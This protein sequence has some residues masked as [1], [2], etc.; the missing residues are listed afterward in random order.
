M[1]RH[2]RIRRSKTQR[3]REEGTKTKAVLD[4]WYWVEQHWHGDSCP[5]TFAD[6]ALALVEELYQCQKAI[7]RGALREP[8]TLEAIDVWQLRRHGNVWRAFGDLCLQHVRTGDDTKKIIMSLE[9]VHVLL[10]HDYERQAELTGVRASAIEK[11]ISLAGDARDKIYSDTAKLLRTAIEA[12]GRQIRD[13]ALSDKALVAFEVDQQD[14]VIATRSIVTKHVLERACQ[15]ALLY[16][17]LQV[18]LLHQTCVID[19]TAARTSGIKLIPFDQYIRDASSVVAVTPSVPPPV[20]SSPGPQPPVGVA[21]QTAPHGVLDEAL[22]WLS[23]EV[24]LRKEHTQQVVYVAEQ[25]LGSHLGRRLAIALAKTDAEEKVEA[26]VA[27]I[28]VL[29]RDGGTVLEILGGMSVAVSYGRKFE[30][31]AVRVLVLEKN[32]E[33]IDQLT[34]IRVRHTCDAVRSRLQLLLRKCL[35]AKRPDCPMVHG[36]FVSLVSSPMSD[37]DSSWRTLFEHLETGSEHELAAVT[38]TDVYLSVSTSSPARIR[39][40]YEYQPRTAWSAVAQAWFRRAWKDS[41]E[42]WRWFGSP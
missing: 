28:D 38:T 12:R 9:V 17:H 35:D 32:Q 41:L 29:A 40:D 7:G 34:R 20:V 30:R 11:W 4:A 15:I 3:D 10:E 39:E 26:K 36:C 5:G 14:L 23:P 2:T 24:A 19:E 13:V 21:E 18:T 6:Y 37:D 22:P 33:I 31:L 16:P 25:D 42:L 1:I 27:C 8:L